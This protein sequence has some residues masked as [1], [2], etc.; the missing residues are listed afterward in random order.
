MPQSSAVVRPT[1]TAVPSETA[2]TGESDEV[3]TVT[4]APPAMGTAVT[5]VPAL[6]RWTSQS[7]TTARPSAG[8]TLPVPSSVTPTGA[9][10][11][12]ERESTWTA[13]SLGLNST[14]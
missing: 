4:A 10:D 7:P 11:R 13:A 9:A 8:F 3:S 6:G 1:T 12:S 14:T 2:E 5:A